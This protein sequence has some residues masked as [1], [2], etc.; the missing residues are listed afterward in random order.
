VDGRR[1]EQRADS[2][3]PSVASLRYVP[4]Y[5]IATGLWWGEPTGD[6]RPDDAGSLV[7]DS[8]IVEHALEI[9]GFP[10]VRLRVSADAPLAH[11]VARLEDVQPD[12]TV[13]LVT[14]K[15]LNG[16][17]RNS[18]LEPEALEP[19]KVYDLEFDLHFTTWTFQPGHRV[20]LAVSNSL[21][22]M[23]WPTP[24][25]M[26]TA[27]HLSVENTRIDLPV[28]PAKQRPAPAFRP[29]EPRDE[30]VDG[31]YVE[32]VPWPFGHYVWTRDL[33]EGRASLEWKGHAEFENHGRRYRTWE[34][35]Y[36][37]TNDLQPAASRFS[38]EGG[39]RIEI[40]DRT[41]EFVSNIDVRSDAEN[42][43][44]TIRRTVREN[45]E[46]VRERTWSEAVP[47][48]FN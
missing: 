37:E 10:R 44:V 4:S 27:L 24:H 13:S 39:R 3:E 28:I 16:S 18:R 38:G 33:A 21:F 30:P 31:Q 46:L 15:L 48:D 45:D 32:S 34:R 20:R 26:T 11:W 35:N 8:E 7:F 9:A 36:Y 2:A 17:Q 1:L 5:G 41:L 19:G 14:G 40:G 43:H 42:F 23:I 6:M 25:P 29:P 12:G 22:P 47:R